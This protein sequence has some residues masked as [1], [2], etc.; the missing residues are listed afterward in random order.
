[1]KRI[2]WLWVGAFVFVSC[3]GTADYNPDK[4]LTASEKDQFKMAVIRYVAKGPENVSREELFDKKYDAY[5]QERAGFS[6]LEQ[7]Y[8]KG[9]EQYFLLT[10]PAPSIV[11]KRHATGGRIVL[12]EDGSIAE[13]EEI[14]R[15]WKMVPDTLKERSYFLFDKMVRGEPLEPY[16]TA[17]SG[18][19]YIEFPD[20]KS[21]YDKSVRAWRTRE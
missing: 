10:Q 17:S 1:M 12:N 13:F 2:F 20:D 18:D 3:S 8:K 11:E 15:T 7:Y 6:F 14:F 4:S 9:N 5:F 21:F 16:Y 19:K